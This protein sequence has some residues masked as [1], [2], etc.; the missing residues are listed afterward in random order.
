MRVRVRALCGLLVRAGDEGLLSLL[1]LLLLLLLTCSRARLLEARVGGHVV[2]DDDE[3]HDEH[4]EVALRWCVGGGCVLSAWS[5]ICR[6]CVAWQGSAAR[7]CTPTLS[8][9]RRA[10]WVRA[11]VSL[12]LAPRAPRTV[13]RPRSSSSIMT[14]MR[15][16]LL[17]ERRRERAARPNRLR[18]REG[19]PRVRACVWAACSHGCYLR[20]RSRACLQLWAIDRRGARV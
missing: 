4:A 16:V 12:A 9:E 20:S 13:K 2:V 18:Q 17:F 8:A 11:T 19:S 1:L 5:S 14:A 3:E 7:A 15:R 10:R 6:A